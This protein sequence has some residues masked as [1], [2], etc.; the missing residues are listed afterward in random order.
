M[1]HTSK[2]RMEYIGTSHLSNVETTIPFF[3]NLSNH[4]SSIQQLSKR[5]KQEEINNHRHQRRVLLLLSTI[6][7]IVMFV[8]SKY[9]NSMI[10]WC[11][12]KFQSLNN[13]YFNA[14]QQ[15][16]TQ[17]NH[18]QSE[19]F[20][21]EKIGATSELNTNTG[22]SEIIVNK[23]RMERRS[24]YK[25]SGVLKDQQM[26][27]GGEE[28]VENTTTITDPTKLQL[29]KSTTSSSSSIRLKPWE[30]KA[31]QKKNELSLE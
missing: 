19:N 20:S 18:H 11:T 1:C 17:D 3:S 2:K 13:K 21:V 25:S 8:N 9:L 24:R 28:N 6:T 29:K 12:V 26:I 5:L 14:S 10:H 23:D 22:N 7:L 30:R 4:N 31:M 16:F 15:Q 27:L